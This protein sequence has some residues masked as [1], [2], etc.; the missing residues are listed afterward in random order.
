MFS[1]YVRRSNYIWVDKFRLVWL[2][3]M[4]SRAICLG[5]V[6][7]VSTYDYAQRV[8]ISVW[9]IQSNC[10][11]SVTQ[12]ISHC[13]WAVSTDIHTYTSCITS[14]FRRRSTLSLKCVQNLQVLF[15][16]GVYRRVIRTRCAMKWCPTVRAHVCT[17]MFHYPLICETVSGQRRCTQHLR[18]PRHWKR[19]CRSPCTVYEKSKLDSHRW[20]N[21]FVSH[22]NSGFICIN[23]IKVS[24]VSSRSFFACFVFGKRTQVR[25]THC[26]YSMGI[27]QTNVPYNVQ[28]VLFVFQLILI[29]IIHNQLKRSMRT[30]HCSGSLYRSHG[31]KFEFNWWLFWFLRVLL[32]LQQRLSLSA[33]INY[34]LKLNLSTK[35]KGKSVFGDFFFW[36][37]F[38]SHPFLM[39]FLE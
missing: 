17:S 20:P 19:Y 5:T 32:L 35:M 31:R 4:L 23:K 10:R 22:T 9:N 34:Y 16:F 7:E 11:R 14:T 18:S 21:F 3:L 24:S 36:K 27:G 30:S 38:V 33:R 2:S 28:Y 26:A 13:W 1:R 25:F 6:N 15:D 8:E 12:C 29:N 37:K 39:W